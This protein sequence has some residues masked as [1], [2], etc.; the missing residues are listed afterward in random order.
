MPWGSINLVSLPFVTVQNDP[1]QG[2]TGAPMDNNI[3]AWQ[4][5]I[6]GPDDTPW[7]GGT[8]QRTFF[9]F[10]FCIDVLDLLM[11]LDDHA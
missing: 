4:A 3:L 9:F 5:V 2:V 8:F 10:S 6:F 7:E 11:D 1:P